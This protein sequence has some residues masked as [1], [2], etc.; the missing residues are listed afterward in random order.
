MLTSKGT[1]ADPGGKRR[2]PGIHAEFRQQAT[3]QLAQALPMLRRLPPRL[4]RITDQLDSGRLALTV[5]PISSLADARLARGL[6]RE[7]ITGVLCAALTICGVA[8]LI[9]GGGPR[10]YGTVDALGYLGGV[11]LLFGF[12]LGAR[13]LA[14]SFIDAPGELA[15]SAGQTGGGGRSAAQVATGTRRTRSAVVPG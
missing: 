12:V 4:D 1:A 8:L 5:H 7:V 9:A 3:G 15:R 11:L 10:L 6:V 2:I 14:A 13:L